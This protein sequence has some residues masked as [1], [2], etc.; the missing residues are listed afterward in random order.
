MHARPHTG[1][2]PAGQTL[3]LA[4][5]LSNGKWKLGLS[6][7]SQWRQRTGAAGD[8]PA[9]L[10]EIAGAKAQFGLSK[11]VEVRSCYEAGRDG[12]W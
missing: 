10:A 1:T 3:Y 2:V 6:D 4:L 11:S 7:G 8:R 5:E 12:F 9:V